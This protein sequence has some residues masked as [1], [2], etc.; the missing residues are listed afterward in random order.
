MLHT[1]ARTHAY[2][3]AHTSAYEEGHAHAQ[4]GAHI[5]HTH[6]RMHAI[7]HARTHTH[8]HTRTHTGAHAHRHAHALA[9]ARARTHTH[10]CTMERLRI[11]YLE[12]G[13]M[14]MSTYSL[15]SH[16]N[17]SHCHLQ[18]TE[19]DN[20]FTWLRHTA[21]QPMHTIMQNTIDDV[22]TQRAPT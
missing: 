18:A 14:P 17:T 8:A 19:A 13:S 6:S 5:F 4:T 11:S 10:T 1:H 21:R 9:H 20:G 16:R 12:H 2:M 15:V 7:M 22:R 3:P